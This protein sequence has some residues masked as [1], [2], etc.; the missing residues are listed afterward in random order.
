MTKFGIV[1]AL[2]EIGLLLRLK[3]GNQ[4]RWRAYGKAAQTI[5]EFDG[6]LAAL[7]EQKQLTEIKGIGPSL[8]AVIEELH[9]SGSSSLLERLRAELPPGVL[10]LSQVPGL[11]LKKI[12]KLNESL[13][14]TNI[15]ELKEAIEAAKIREVPGFGAKTESALLER[16]SRL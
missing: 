10:T 3:P 2:Q 11:T 15:G 4:F 12:K 6:D 13:G 8:A 1:A 16:I 7:I 5:A 14:I 9:A